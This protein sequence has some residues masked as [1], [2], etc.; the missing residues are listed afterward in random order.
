MANEVRQHSAS[1]TIHSRFEKLF[2]TLFQTVLL[3]I[4]MALMQGCNAGVEKKAVAPPKAVPV[5]LKKIE[6]HNVAA[7]ITLVGRMDSRNSVDLFPRIDG[8]VAKINITPG[9]VVKPGQMLI[10]IDSNKQTAAVAAKMSSVE[11]AKADYAKEVGKLGSLEAEVDARQSGVDYNSLEYQRYYWLEKRGVVPTSSVDKEDRDLKVAKSRLAQLQAEITAQRDVIV[12][13]K[14]RIDEA[15]A[16]LK[17][18]QAELA[19]HIMRAPFGGVIGDVPVKIGDYINPQSKLTK[20]SKTNPLEVNIEVPQEHVKQIRV[21][22]PLEILDNGGKS[23]GDIVVSYVSPTV[24]LQNQSVLVKGEYMNGANELRPDQ[25]VQVRITLARESALTVPTEAISFV[26]GKAFIF[27]AQQDGAGKLVSNQR[28]I[29]ISSI[30]DNQAT[31][32]SGLKTGE[33]VVVS[34][35]QLLGDKTP[36]D[37]SEV[38]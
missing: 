7:T 14:K 35:I 4:V 16:E 18:E 10:E 24:N 25:T 36:I 22:T 38:P 37:A 28:P 2:S 34:G 32:K 29:E 13:A 30:E 19:Y 23:F 11:L 20:V 6:A 3:V 8:Y 15:N 5:K 26:A 9:M 1:D 31:V 27:V 21:G 33:E 17:A 12:R